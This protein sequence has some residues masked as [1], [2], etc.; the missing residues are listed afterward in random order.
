MAVLVRRMAGGVEIAEV[1]RDPQV[2]PLA[3]ESCGHDR[4]DNQDRT[5]ESGEKIA[6]GFHP[7]LRRETTCHS[8][9][10]ESVF[11]RVLSRT[12]RACVCASGFPSKAVQA[13]TP[14]SS[15]LARV[16]SLS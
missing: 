9:L 12:R 13:D 5:T 11:R 2:L 6:G 7:A 14:F 3:H 10:T 8:F 1:G 16:S 15:A 4:Q